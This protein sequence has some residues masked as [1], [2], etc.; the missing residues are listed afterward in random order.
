M[1]GLSR[2]E[3]ASLI[4]KLNNKN[5]LNV[6]QSDKHNLQHHLTGS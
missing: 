5:K 2:H 4:F 3:E 6:V 1:Q